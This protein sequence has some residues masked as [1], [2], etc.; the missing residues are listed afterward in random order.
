MKMRFGAILL[1]LALLLTSTVAL[2]QSPVTLAVEAGL[3][4]HYT[5]G[6]WLP[7]RVLIENDGP[8]IDGRV[9]I[10]CRA[11]TEEK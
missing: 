6:Q 11:P 5:V 3:D 8:S 7:V 1:S 2:A 9:E 10:T 4:G